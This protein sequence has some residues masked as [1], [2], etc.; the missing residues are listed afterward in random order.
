MPS[1]EEYQSVDLAPGWLRDSWG[2]AYNGALGKRK[3]V[4]VAALKESV[5]ARM[6][7]L[8]PPDALSLLAAER[9]IDRGAGE[10]EASHRARVKA[11]WGA[12]R[13]AGTPVGLLTAFYWGGYRPASGKVVLQTQGDPVAGGYQYELRSDFDPAIHSPEN[14]LIVTPLGVVS[15]GGAPAELWQDFAVLFVPPMLPS[16]S[17]APPSNASDEVEGIRTMITRWKP[18]HSRC[19]QLK[20]LPGAAWGVGGL[21]WGTFLWGGGPAPTI[22]TPPT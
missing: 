6:P 4:A 9:G 19:V 22:W 18:A 8:A 5:K 14:A 7:S 16:W 17:P 21:T 15:L 13:W 10:A 12:W 1:F 3:D 11:A 2:T 20:A